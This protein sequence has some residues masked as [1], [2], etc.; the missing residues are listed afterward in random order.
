LKKKWLTTPLQSDIKFRQ[1]KIDRNLT[2]AS[3]PK[4]ILFG[5]YMIFIP[6]KLNI[7]IL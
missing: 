4:L 1:V 7:S 2:S 3:N 6:M 5:I